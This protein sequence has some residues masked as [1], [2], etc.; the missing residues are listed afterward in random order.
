PYLLAAFRELQGIA[1][2]R[3]VGGR[4]DDLIDR[5][6]G[7]PDNVEIVGPRN[8][9]DLAAEFR[10]ADIFVLPS[11]ED[12]SAYVLL[13]AM[14]AGLPVVTTDQAGAALL[15]D[16]KSGFIVRAG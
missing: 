13:E 3:I 14:Q 15:D 8:G 16:G 1:R 6:G 9:P 10:D 7:A 12:G 11:I 5:L 2:L 4:N